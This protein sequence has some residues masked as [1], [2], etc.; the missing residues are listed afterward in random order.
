[1]ARY[2]LQPLVEVLSADGA[3]EPLHEGS[4]RQVGLARVTTRR[5]GC[6]ASARRVGQK[7]LGQPGLADT[8]LSL[9]HHDV[10]H[11]PSGLVGPEQGTPLGL[12]PDERVFA[13]P[14]EGFAGGRDLRLLRPLGR[15]AFPGE[16]RGWVQAVLLDGLVDPG[17]LLQRGDAELPFQDAHALAVLAQSGGALPRPRVELHQPAV[18]RLVQGIQSH[19]A[20]CIGNSSLPLFTRAEAEAE[21]LQR[22]CQ[23]A[24]Q[25]L[26]LEE[27]PVVEG[28]AVAQR[29]PRQEVVAV[30]RHRFGEWVKALGADL[31]L[32]V[33]VR[34]ALG[35]E[36]VEAIHVDPDLVPEEVHAL[37][38]GHQPASRTGDA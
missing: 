11:R 29:E 30:E 32:R 4:V 12:P 23:L 27:L 5:D 19:P 24:A 37:P 9:E 26:A 21:P 16:R 13:R 7:L 2:P 14:D 35:Q 15:R 25:L 20:A 8:G 28:G 22:P 10:P 36:L 17:S 3:G 31:A 33:A 18:R 34:P 1:V 38:V 6:R